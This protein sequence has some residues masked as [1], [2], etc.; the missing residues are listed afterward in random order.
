MLLR[1]AE[2]QRSRIV[3]VTVDGAA[4]AVV[5]AAVLACYVLLVEVVPVQVD[6][7]LLLLWTL[8][9]L[10]LILLTV[11]LT[12]VC[13]QPVP[14]AFLHLQVLLLLINVACYWLRIERWSI[15]NSDFNGVCYFGNSLY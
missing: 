9:R 2:A 15:C 1:E 11:I 14:M 10:G 5:L 13:F 7:L 3:R 8:L 12:V 6:D 4:R